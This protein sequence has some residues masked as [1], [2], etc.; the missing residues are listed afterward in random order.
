MKTKAPDLAVVERRCG[1]RS[2]RFQGVERH[3]IIADFN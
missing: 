2:R 1:I 3:T